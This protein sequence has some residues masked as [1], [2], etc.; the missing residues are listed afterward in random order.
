MW[1]NPDK[2]SAIK[3]AFLRGL[4]SMDIIGAASSYNEGIWSK[5]KKGCLLNL[6]IGKLKPPETFNWLP[7]P[8]K[9]ADG[10]VFMAPISNFTQ[11]V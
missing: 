9:T 11:K 10:K 2:N 4:E 7:Q 5:I 8:I 1:K 3:N 6:K